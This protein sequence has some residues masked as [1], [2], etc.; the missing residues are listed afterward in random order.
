MEVNWTSIDVVR[1]G[2][3][4][5]WYWYRPVV[6][7]IGV[8]PGSLSGAVVVRKCRELLEEY[9]IFDVDVEI[10]ESIVWGRSYS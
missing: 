5:E 1:I 8:T 10:R 7:W 2:I 3:E 9:T 6:L 4:D